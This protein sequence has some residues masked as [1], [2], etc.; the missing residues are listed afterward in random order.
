MTID[1]PTGFQFNTTGGTYSV[2]GTSAN[3]ITAVSI[4][5]ITTSRITVR[6]SVSNSAQIDMNTLTISCQIRGSAA[7]SS[8]TI[9]RSGGTLKL[10]RSSS[11]PSAGQSLGNLTGYQS[12]SFTSCTAAH[13]TTASVPQAIND[14][15]ILQVQ[16]V[17]TGTCSLINLTSL[18]F[19]TNG[20]NGTGSNN[21][22][23]NIT[24]A[25]VYYTGTNSTYS[26]SGI[27]GTVSSPNGSFTVNG[28]QVLAEGTNYFWL[29][30]DVPAGAIAGE[31]LDAACNSV[32]LDGGV[33]A[34]VPTTQTPAGSRSI[35][36]TTQF[37]S[38]AS[39]N[40][41]N[42]SNWSLSDG[43]PSCTCIPTN[44]GNVI[45][46][47]NHVITLDMTDT[48]SYLTL[49]TGSQFKDN[50]SS[51]FLI[52]SNLNIQG[53]AYLT[54]TSPVTVNGNLFTSGSGAN[55]TSS[56]LTVK[57]NTTIG[58]GTSLTSSASAGNNIT[59]QGQIALNGN[60]SSGSNGATII[61]NG[62]SA[63]TLS[64]TGTIT[65]SGALTLSTSSK[66]ISSGSTINITPDVAISGTTTVTNNGTLTVTGNITGTV[67]GST[68]VN[69][70]NAILHV[71]GAVLTTGTLTAT[72]SPNTID[73][74][75]AGTQTIK[76]T[77]Y[78]IL[79]L[80]NS[81]TKTFGG[82]T[83]INS[84]LNISG[85]VSAVGGTNTL[86]GAGNL[87]MSGTS[88]LTI[89]KTGVTVPEFTGIYQLTSGTINFNPTTASTQVLRG[90]NYYNLTLSGSNAASQFDLT[91]V[92]DIANVFSSQNQ[93][94][95]INNP[96]MS[97]AGDFSYTSSGTSALA[98]DI[99]INGSTTVSAGN[100][101]LNT[102]YLTTAGLT[103]ASGATLNA[104]G[105]TI[106]ITDA[107]GWTNNGGTFTNSTSTVLFSG[108]AN[109]S[110]GGSSSTTFNNLTLSNTSSAPAYTLGAAI[111]VAG[112]L[113]FSSGLADFNGNTLT[114]GS[115][116]ASTGTM[117]Y[118]NGWIYN[119][120][121]KRWYNTATVA[122]SSMAA[123]FPL[124]TSA[125]ARALYVNAPS[126]APS[127]GGTVSISHTGGSGTSTVN[128]SD[129]ATQIDRL[130]N[131]SWTIST[132]DGLTGGTWNITT[133]GT[134]L[135]ALSSITP[136][137]LTNAAGVTGTAGTNS[138]STSN[139]QVGRTGIA[140]ASLGNTY[141][142]G[143]SSTA[144]PVEMVSF[145]AKANNKTIE[146]KWVTASELNS[147]YFTLFRSA[148]GMNF[149]EISKIS[150]K[151]YSSTFSYYDF[152]DD[153]PFNGINYYKLTETDF[154][155]EVSDANYTSANLKNVSS[156]H[157]ISNPVQDVLA[158]DMKDMSQ[159][160]VNLRIFDCSGRLIYNESVPATEKLKI[161]C[162]VFQ[163]GVYLLDADNGISRFRERFVKQ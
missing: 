102:K 83:T 27:F 147:N 106:E 58:S 152:T 116:A 136:L 43:G 112:T 70:T 163:T 18:Q 75:N 67:A 61:L 31:K 84:E 33:G 34:Q 40:W 35:T 48:V 88:E 118:T 104:T 96:V 91:N 120:T 25:K 87:V 13:S 17:M 82:N 133:Y 62:A 157:I 14:I 23:T 85:T 111:Q 131:S 66:T 4:S 26:P 78:H 20:G 86:S 117:S 151:G 103:L 69:S 115:S 81:G 73:Y 9:F 142:W 154:D 140:L 55:T 144:L 160:I 127:A 2:T 107:G 137:R 1:L 49:S 79:Q 138:G 32:T 41:S 99:T 146:L 150:A 132:A 98:N 56:S 5:A 161:D 158:F 44:A 36:G 76:G 12:M 28:S 59:L 53:T 38:I 22:T 109:Q 47:T 50:G 15:E 68:F 156:P 95:F 119:G 139:P 89:A 60:L 6:M 141:Y 126:S 143:Y 52:T 110:I 46:D 21:P 71:A 51:S 159:S 135:N 10:N 101:N 54:S 121:L 122:N 45:I 94:I 123:L 42:T 19:N 37:Y 92:T 7:G 8:G 24:R 65:G 130:Y 80:T 64:G 57:L 155:G 148:D 11:N 16:V 30:Y 105:S 125:N 90:V 114:L 108:T 97:V 77:T 145:D 153:K 100:L 134:G 113:T 129:G 128:F 74:N 3:D 39:G 93:S 63:Q 124:G 149:T 162:T 72:A 29:A